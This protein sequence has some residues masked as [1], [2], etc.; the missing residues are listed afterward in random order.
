MECQMGGICGKLRLGLGQEKWMDIQW[1]SHLVKN[2]ELRED[3]L[4]RYQV[5]SFRMLNWESLILRYIPL[6]IYQVEMETVNL[7]YIHWERSIY[8]VHNLELR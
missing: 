6:V 5:E 2:L 1:E 3:T 8:L 4:L 7:R